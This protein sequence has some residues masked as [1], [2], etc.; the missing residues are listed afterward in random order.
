MPCPNPIIKFKIKQNWA[1]FLI[2][3]GEV[4]HDKIKV[5]DH[6]QRL[7]MSCPYRFFLRIIYF[8]S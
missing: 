6:K 3:I 7:W 5:N 4:G 8:F 2:V 1:L